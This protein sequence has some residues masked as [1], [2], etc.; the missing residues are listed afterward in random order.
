M[1]IKYLIEFN[2]TIL[3]ITQGDLLM[4]SS[5]AIQAAHCMTHENG[6]D[7]PMTSTQLNNNNNKKKKKKKKRLFSAALH[8]LFQNGAL[9]LLVSAN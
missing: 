9:L 3:K 5:G 1:I 8:P 7:S 2:D 4:Y 6:R